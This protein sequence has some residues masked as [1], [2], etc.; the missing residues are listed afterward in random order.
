LTGPAERGKL[1]DRMAQDFSIP[2]AT[3]RVE[4]GSGVQPCVLVPDHV[5]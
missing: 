5:V 1:A 2:H 4:T 3:L